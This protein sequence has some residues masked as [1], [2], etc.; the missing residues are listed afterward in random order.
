MNRHYPL[1]ELRDVLDEVEN[2]ESSSYT[3]YTSR[4]HPL[5]E[6]YEPHE[7]C[8]FCGNPFDQNPG[9]VEI[10]HPT[11]PEAKSDTLARALYACRPAQ[12]ESYEAYETGYEIWQ[13][14][15]RAVE[16]ELGPWI[17][18]PERF[19]ALALNGCYHDPE[20]TM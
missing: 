5:D 15:I 16:I 11:L 2:P 9:W 7:L 18:E 13:E 8:E 14:C 3:R 17:K 19:R 4:P 20:E 1:H 12:Y 10:S 6:G